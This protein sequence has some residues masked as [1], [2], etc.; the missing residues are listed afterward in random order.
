[1]VSIQSLD[2]E[3]APAMATL[4]QRNRD[5]LQAFEPVREDSFFTVSCQEEMI[6]AALDD[7]D[8]FLFGIY[9]DRQLIG[10]L[11]VTGVTRGAFQN[12]RFGYWIGE[13]HHNHGYMTEA[14]R[15]GIQF[16]FGTMRLHRL[17][18]NVMPRNIP[19]LRVLEK[20]GFE[21]I[22]LARNYLQI[23]GRWED[24]YLHQLINPLCEPEP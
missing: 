4:Y 23:N 5:Y 10:R 18:A 14:V 11:S 15:Q 20:C 19:S 7:P 22:G 17:E 8:L 21:R 24:H 1:M 12:G 3:D 6:V 13:D 2:W 16:C 9:L